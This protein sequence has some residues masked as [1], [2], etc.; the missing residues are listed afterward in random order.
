[1]AKSTSIVQAPKI[2]LKNIVKL[3]V[4]ELCVVKEHS[5]MNSHKTKVSPAEH[6]IGKTI[7]INGGDVTPNNTGINPLLTNINRKQTLDPSMIIP[8]QAMNPKQPHHTKIPQ[9]LQHITPPIVIISIRGSKLFEPLLLLLQNL[10]NGTLLHQRLKE[11]QNP[12]HIPGLVELAQERDLLFGLVLHLGTILAE[13]LELVD[14]LVDHVPQPLVG[15]LHVYNTV[16][17]HLEKAAVVVPGVDALAERGR[18]ARVEVAEP[19]L[20]VEEA[21]NV[22][23]IHVMRHGV[24][25]GPR[26]VLEE[27]LRQ[28]LERTLV[29]LVDLVHVLLADVTVQVNDERFH[30]VRDEVRV[31]PELLRLWALFVV[32]VRH[33][34]NRVWEGRQLPRQS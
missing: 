2:N 26:R 27:P 20:A 9:H 28:G 10:N 5:D 4:H 24:H 8:Q 12:I 29:H 30:R 14:E 3:S 13:A 19:H 25:G 17:D 6:E 33:A 18:E 32:L 21:K 15:E 34:W 16:E 11:V 1:M 23:V 22:V 7:V 31:V